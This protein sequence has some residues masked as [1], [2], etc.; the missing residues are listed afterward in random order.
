MPTMAKAA[1]LNMN[2]CFHTESSFL[3]ARSL[4]GGDHRKRNP[5]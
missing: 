2:L 1:S 5:A 4:T 3:L